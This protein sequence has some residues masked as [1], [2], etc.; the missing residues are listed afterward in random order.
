MLIR[1]AAPIK[2]APAD[3]TRQSLDD[4]QPVGF[5]PLAAISGQMHTAARIAVVCCIAALA[6]CGFAGSAAAVDAPAAGQFIVELE[7]NGDANVVFTDEF[8]LTDAEDRAAFEDAQSNAELRAAAA[9]QFR[10]EMQFVSDEASADLDRELRVGEVTVETAVDDETGI[11]AY[12]FR[13]ENLARIEDDRLV[14]SEP[15]STY[16]SLDRELVVIAPEGE[17]LTSVS[18]RP[19]RLGEE[20]AT[21]PGLTQFGERFEVV[22]TGANGSA[23]AETTADLDPVSHSPANADTYGGAPIA[24]GVAVLLLGSLLVGRER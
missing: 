15:F 6:L 1:G 5:W 24:L 2:S 13:W 23:A 19:E 7:P 3:P 8:D 14:L 21:W 9:Q 18:P 17:A 20:A 11:V 12:Q 22:A 4:V 16:D 10:E